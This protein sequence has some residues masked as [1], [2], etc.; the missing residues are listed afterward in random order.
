MYYRF[1]YQVE[2][3]AW[4]S[5]Y[6]LSH[7]EKMATKE[8]EEEEESPETTEVWDWRDNLESVDTD[9]PL[10]WFCVMYRCIWR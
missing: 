3:G 10:G 1:E 6:L 2:R 8:E 7:L 4:G 9:F 5:I